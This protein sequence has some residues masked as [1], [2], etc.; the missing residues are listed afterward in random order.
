MDLMSA[1]NIESVYFKFAEVEDAVFFR[2][3]F[4]VNQEDWS[5]TCYAIINISGEHQHTEDVLTRQARRGTVL[6]ILALFDLNI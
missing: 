3:C 6:K 4:S 5:K 1:A 2:L